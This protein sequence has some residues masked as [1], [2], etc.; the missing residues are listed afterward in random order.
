MTLSV[1]LR[2][3]RHQLAER[4][5]R[6]VPVALLAID[7]R[8]DHHRVQGI[9]VVLSENL[10]AT[11]EDLVEYRDGDT[12]LEGILA[13]DD[14]Q[15]GPRPGVLVSHA[16]GGR[17]DFEDGKARALAEL[18]YAGF[19]L[20]LYGKGVRGS[21]PEENGALMQPFLDDRAMLQQRLL[22]SLET[23]RAQDEVAADT[24]A[25][26]GFCFGGLCVLD[27]ARTGADIAGVVSFHGLFM[28]PG[29]TEGNT[30]TARVLALHGWDD[31]MAPPDAAVALGAELSAMGADWQLHAYGNTMHA[32]TNPAANDSQM[33]TV[34]DATAERRSWQAM[35]N[36]LNELFNG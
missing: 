5:L 18:G 12:V 1:L 15:S 32:F 6:P 31:P 21:N 29:N 28:P 4:C 3:P 25:A 8:Q 16:W 35:Q 36:F 34:Y 27:I 22:V 14:A 2:A 11:G 26:I 24:V 20:D 19:A 9:R 10:P 13:W 30:V 33:G 23:L 17:S 7:E